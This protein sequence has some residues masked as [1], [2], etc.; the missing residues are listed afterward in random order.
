MK[1]IFDLIAAEGKRQQNTIDLIASENYSLP[2]VQQALASVLT[3]K[4]AE[5]YPGKRYYA[6]CE[7]VDQI[8][9]VAIDACK[10][11]FAAEHANVQPHSGSQ[12]NMAIYAAF[13]KPGDTILGMDLAAGGHLTHGSPVNFSGQFY[14]IVSYGVDSTTELLDYDA[15]EQRALEHKP[16]L[17]IAGSSAYSR[18][19]DFKRFKKI[20]DKINAYFVAD[21]A[22]LA[23]LIV[24]GLHESPV[25]YADAVSGTTHKTLRGPRGGFILCK[26]EHQERIDRAVFPG[27]QGGPMMNV[28]AAKALAFSYAMTSDF[29]QYQQ[30]AADNATV[31]AQTFAHKGYRIVSGGTDTHMFIVDLSD[32]G[33]T[34]LE[35]Q[36]LLE[37]AG[38]TVSRSCIPGDKQKPWIGSGTR[39]GTNAITTRGM[40]AHECAF[41]VSLIDELLQEPDNI[42]TLERVKDH[43]ENLCEMFPIS[44]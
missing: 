23:G 34:G 29:V 2:D 8:E 38:I 18:A 14:T 21:I 44:E 13:L 31:M 3:N 32:K 22:H 17:I 30:M 4:Y 16:Q 26:K 43:I 41:I 37:A 42:E 24:A 11:V 39:I 6:G 36:R 10:Q 12:A 7:V 19:I 35:A 15:I 40:G 33:I 9:Q 5:G 1:K 28:I 25:P 27:I 20:A